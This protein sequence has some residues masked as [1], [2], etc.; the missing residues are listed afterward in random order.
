M[1]TPR[2]ASSRPQAEQLTNP[3]VMTAQ[4]APHT[5]AGDEPEAYR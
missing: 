3:L 4:N 2:L 5:A 1:L